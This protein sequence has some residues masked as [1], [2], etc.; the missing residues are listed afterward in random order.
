MRRRLPLTSAAEGEQHLPA[1]SPP[2]RAAL[3]EL[4]RALARQQADE[5]HHADAARRD[6]RQ[7]Q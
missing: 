6:L 4:V 1:V 2:L 5:D 7:V 3:V